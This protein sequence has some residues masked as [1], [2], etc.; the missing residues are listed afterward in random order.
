MSYRALA[1]M[2]HVASQLIYRWI[3]CP[4]PCGFAITTQLDVDRASVSDWRDF[5]VFLVKS[6]D[7]VQSWWAVYQRITRDQGDRLAQAIAS[8]IKVAK[9]AGAHYIVFGDHDYPSA[10]LHISDP[11]LGLTFTGDASLLRRQSVSVVGSRKA[12]PFAVHQSYM[13]GARFA[14]HGIVVVSGGAFGCDIASHFGVLASGVVSA[15]AICVFA[16]GLSC[17]YPRSNQGVF[18]KLQRRSGL[19]LTERLWDAP[20]RPRDFTARNRIIAGL[21]RT[22]LVM[23]A[24]QRSGALVT[25]R[26]AL[27]QGA[28]VLVL[29]HPSDDIR[30]QGSQT[31]LAEG[32]PGF[33]DAAD[34]EPWV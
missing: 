29:R 5:I 12:S 18:A 20:C 27:D 24:A 10:L 9:A 19:M 16:G 3:P 23:Q 15:P 6:L 8:H 34:L 31:L 4:D 7:Y 1:V 17:L 33:D 26:R 28:D 21:S 11:P 32:A 25:A 14:E 22:T 30:A 2:T 13:V